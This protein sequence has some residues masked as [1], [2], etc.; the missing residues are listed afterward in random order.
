[1]PG[2]ADVYLITGIQAAG[3]STAEILTRART[4]AAVR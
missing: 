3:K 1:M 2:A 4:E